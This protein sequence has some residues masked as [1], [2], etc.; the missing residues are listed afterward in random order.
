MFDND[1]YFK[2]FEMQNQSN[3]SEAF[4]KLAENSE[5]KHVK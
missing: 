5:T 3:Y 4:K 2:I 1:F